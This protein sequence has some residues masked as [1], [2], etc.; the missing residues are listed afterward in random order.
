MGFKTSLALITGKLT[1]FLLNILN[2]AGTQFPGTMAL[3]VDPD[4]IQHMK[5]PEN[6]IAVT[7][8]NG[9]TTTMNFLS[10]M[11]E[12]LNIDVISN[13]AGS[14]TDSGVMTVF[15]ENTSYF[16]KIKNN[17]S[18]LEMDE[19][20]ARRILPFIG[21]RSLTVTNLFQDSYKRNGNIFFVRKRLEEALTGEE[22]LILNATDSISSAM[23]PDHPNRVYFEVRPLF[24][25]TEES[26]NRIND[27]PYC[28]KCKSKID[29]SFRRYHHIGYYSCSSCSYTNPKA[30]YSVLSYR[31]EDQ[32]LEILD[33]GEKLRIPCVRK[34]VE[35][36]YNQIAA[37]ATLRENGFSKEELLLSMQELQVTK[38]RL[39]EDKIG[40]KTFTLTISKGY[41]PVALSRSLASVAKTLG[42]K[43]LYMVYYDREYQG[44]TPSHLDAWA[45]QGDWEN[46]EKIDQL[47]LE[48]TQGDLFRVAAL[49]SGIPEDKIKL[50]NHPKEAMKYFDPEVE[51]E[52]FIFCDIEEVN[53]ADARRVVD[54]YRS[55]V[56]EGL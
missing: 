14:N 31:E 28:P 11:L 40:K 4:L 34:N 33:H 32:S 22:I 5:K 16:G 51:E 53:R 36:I 27:L 38:Q 35:T 8:T 56:K 42:R 46:L 21:I 17:H 26:E 20:W 19:L 9:K 47:I 48:G 30:S 3:K 29:W 12:N 7:G 45:F 49:L 25:E 37:Y 2:K 15:L 18:V 44:T 54:C 1:K 39:V 13:R 24:F 6:I 55:Y 50:V 41:N 10:D 52:I 23:A 43:T